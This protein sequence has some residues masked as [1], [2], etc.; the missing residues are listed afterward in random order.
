MVCIYIISKSKNQLVM[1]SLIY[2]KDKIELHTSGLGFH[3]QAPVRLRLL[4]LEK[5]HI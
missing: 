2:N 3:S 4:D 5:K 1:V